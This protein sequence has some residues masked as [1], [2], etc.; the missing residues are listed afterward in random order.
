MASLILGSDES[1]HFPLDLLDTITAGRG[2]TLSPN[3]DGSLGFLLG[4][5]NKGDGETTTL[6]MAGIEWYCLT[7]FYLAE[8]CL[9]WSFS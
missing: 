2:A 9:S 3:G 8:L 4:L 7:V 1:P 5:A 6:P